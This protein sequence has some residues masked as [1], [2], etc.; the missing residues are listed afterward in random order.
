[1]CLIWFEDFFCSPWG[2]KL[3]GIYQ[4]RKVSISR[5]LV[6]VISA[7][8]YILECSFW[9]LWEFGRSSNPV[10]TTPPPTVPMLVMVLWWKLKVLE[11]S[12]SCQEFRELKKIWHTFGRVFSFPTSMNSER[13][14]VQ[15]S[16]VF[17]TH[18]LTQ[19][20]SW[21]HKNDLYTEVVKAKIV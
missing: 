21:G 16:Q 14:I 1:M 13:N 7:I 20:L 5:H 19:L 8:K 15:N 2:E 3:N 4:H 6:A 17:F 11:R 10:T 9:Q 12:N 18:Q